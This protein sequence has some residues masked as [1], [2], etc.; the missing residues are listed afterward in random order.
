MPARSGSGPGASSSAV[1]RRTPGAPTGPGS[2][3]PAPGV[4]R[5]HAR[6]TRSARGSPGRRRPSSVRF[7]S[8]PETTARAGISSPPARTTPVARR[9]PGGTLATSAPVR[10]SRRTRGP[11]L[12]AP[13]PGRRAAPRERRL[14]GR[15][16]VVAGRV[17]E[18]HGGGA[19]R[20]RA[21][22]RELDAAPGDRAADLVRLEDLADQVGDGH[23]QHPKGLPAGLRPQLPERPAEAEPG[24]GV[25]HR[26]RLDVGRRGRVQVGQEARDRPDPPVEGEEGVGV[27][28]RAAAKVLRGAA[29]VRPQRHGLR[30]RA[31]ARTPGRTA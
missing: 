23:R 21:H 27:L 3:W 29:G 31:A 11:R 6:H 17:A 1:G 15:A 28:R 12:P 2:P 26:R 5:F 16:A 9:R 22:G 25:G 7:G 24:H 10:I 20:P 13:R 8:A 4:R 18:Q 19:R 14:P 30:R